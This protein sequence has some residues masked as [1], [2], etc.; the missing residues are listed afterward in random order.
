VKL[1]VIGDSPGTT[2]R[3][4]A[5]ESIFIIEAAPD[6][7]PYFELATLYI[8][9]LQQ[10]MGIQQNILKSLAMMT[11][12]VGTSASFEGLDVEHDQQVL[13]GEN[14]DELIRRAIRLLRDSQERLRLQVNGLQRVQE[15]YSWYQIANRYEALFQAMS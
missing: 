7:R 1:Y 2:L 9:P 13:I 15:R 3:P 10:R 6:L 4:Y 12:V 11:P 8:S 14:D 5:S